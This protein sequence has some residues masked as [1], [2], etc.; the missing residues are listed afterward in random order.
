MIGT[1]RVREYLRAM[2]KQFYQINIPQRSFN[3]MKQDQK[4]ISASVAVNKPR[5][6]SQKYTVQGKN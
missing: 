1:G 2:S 5:R 6:K 3:S 4:N